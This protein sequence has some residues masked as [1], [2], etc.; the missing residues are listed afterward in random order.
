MLIDGPNEVYMI[1][2]D[3][4]VFYVPHLQVSTVSELLG[5]KPFFLVLPLVICSAR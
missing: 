5:T 1:D 3:N 2:R 4:T